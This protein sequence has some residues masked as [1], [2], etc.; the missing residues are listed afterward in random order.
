MAHGNG[1]YM[2]DIKPTAASTARSTQPRRIPAPPPINRQRA[3]KPPVLRP[4]YTTLIVVLALVT[5]LLLVMSLDF[6]GQ[7][8]S[9]GAA[10]EPAMVNPAPLLEGAAGVA[11][12]PTPLPTAVRTATPTLPPPPGC[13]WSP[14]AQNGQPITA[15][16]CLH[17]LE[18]GLSV[19]DGGLQIY[20]NSSQDRGLFGFSRPLP[21]AAEIALQVDVDRLFG[22]ELWIALAPGLDPFQGGVALVIQE[23]GSVDVRRYQGGVSGE[24]ILVDNAIIPFVSERGYQIAILVSG[25]RV[26][27]VINGRKVSTA[28]LTFI[29]RRLFLG[30]RALPRS[31]A[32]TNIDVLISPPEFP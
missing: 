8:V 27:F 20:R 21:S 10:P 23:G 25:T 7:S 9:A 1:S 31:G 28:E 19:F 18:W 24:S 14:F 2:S 29:D 5:A 13:E 16:E 17:A 4:D 6:T 26:E 30:Y 11:D 32:G 3:G 15:Q 12:E 22:G